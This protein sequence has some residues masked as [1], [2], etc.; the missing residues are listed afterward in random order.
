MRF[1]YWKKKRMADS[2][3]S[4]KAIVIELSEY[5]ESDFDNINS[6]ALKLL[7]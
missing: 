3:K 1:N 5:F 2:K 6:N 4:A 7:N